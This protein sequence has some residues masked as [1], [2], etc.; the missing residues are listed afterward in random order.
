G[1]SGAPVQRRSAIVGLALVIALGVLSRK[2]HLGLFVWDKSLGDAL[3]TVMIYFVAALAR[4][5]WRPARL[6]AAAPGISVAIGLFQATGIPGRL[7]RLLQIVLGTT[8][9]WHDIACYVVGALLVA[10][11]HTLAAR[12]RA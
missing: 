9:A 10:L 2:V 11:G 4:P 8:F 1:L 5:A 3:Y 12:V 6:R 7:P